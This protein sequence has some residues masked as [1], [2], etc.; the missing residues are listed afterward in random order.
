MEKRVCKA[1]ETPTQLRHE[2]Q[3]QLVR[4]ELQSWGQEQELTVAPPR[5]FKKHKAALLPLTYIFHVA[6]KV[7]ELW[8]APCSAPARWGGDVGMFSGSTVQTSSSESRFLRPAPH[9][10]FSLPSFLCFFT[11]LPSFTGSPR[12]PVATQPELGQLSWLTA[13]AE[14]SPLPVSQ[15]GL[16]PSHRL[17]SQTPFGSQGL[18]PSWPGEEALL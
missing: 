8:P 15:A 2:C 6:H 16:S 10:P 9:L 4:G 14:P 12:A 17:C 13:S 7:S 1:P 11:L 5:Q 3:H 18:T